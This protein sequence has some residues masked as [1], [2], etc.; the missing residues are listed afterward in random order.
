MNDMSTRNAGLQPSNS[1]VAAQSS[2]ARSLDGGGKG[3]GASLF[4]QEN[5]GSAQL[6]G[7]LEA[8]H[9]DDA[10]DSVIVINENGII[11]MTNRLFNRMFG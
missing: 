11:L 2:L 5:G 3:G 7:V 10:R 1:L 6:D 8:G 9:V 4:S